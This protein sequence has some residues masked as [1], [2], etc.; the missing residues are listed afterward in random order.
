MIW[1]LKKGNPDEV[2]ICSYGLTVLTIVPYPNF[3]TFQRLRRNAN[4]FKDRNLLYLNNKI[5]VLND[6]PI[7]PKELAL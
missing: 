7:V 4:F 2:C 6:P 3:I 1:S 5:E